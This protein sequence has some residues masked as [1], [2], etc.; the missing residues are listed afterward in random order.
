MNIKYNSNKRLFIIA[1][2]FLF[3]IPFIASETPSKEEY[4]KE[5]AKNNDVII[6]LYY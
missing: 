2:L 3:I 1:L 4:Y 5:E 6:Q